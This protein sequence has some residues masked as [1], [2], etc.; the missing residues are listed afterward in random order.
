MFKAMS[1]W[2]SGSDRETFLKCFGTTKGDEW[3]SKFEKEY[4][5][6]SIPVHILHGFDVKEP[7]Y[8]TTSRT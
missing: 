5:C 7:R 4:G 6:A 1:L 3:Y 2:N 8:K